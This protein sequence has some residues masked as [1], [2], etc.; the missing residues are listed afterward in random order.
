MEHGRFVLGP[1]VRLLEARLADF[2]QRCYA[3]G[4]GT[5][6]DALLLGLRS[7]D[8]G[9]GDEVITTP[10]SWLASTST[11]LL[12]GATAV[13]GDIGDDLNLDPST[14]EPL[15]TPSTKAILPVHF[16]GRICRMG[17][18]KEIASR[19]NL[20]VIEDGSQAFGAT[21]AGRPTGSFGDVACISMN[22]M[23][24]LGAL[25]D[26]GVVLTDDPKISERLDLLRHSGV[27]DRDYCYELSHNCRLDTIQAA[28]L[29]KRLDRLSSVLQRRRMLSQRYT[30]ALSSVVDTPPFDTESVDAIYTYVIQTECRDELKAFL[31]LHKIETK[32]QHPIVIND[33]PAF[34]GR[35]RGDS[36]K[37]R[38]AVSRILCLPCSEKLSE[39]QQDYVIATVR[40][41]FGV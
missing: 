10:L 21:L 14:I 11:I 30:R 25:G 35:C 1:E 7:L 12:C 23:K 31:E 28:I 5:G 20:K 18:I 38:S 3:I 33:Q 26:A 27:R 34:Q 39:E 9:S 8:I 41:F 19:Y 13:F 2:C 6:T 37:A 4:V 36:P 32:I 16:T 15:I 24:V 17:E 22:A 40:S 29:L